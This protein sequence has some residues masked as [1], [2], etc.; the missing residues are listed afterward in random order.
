MSKFM[1]TAL[2]FKISWTFSI[3]DFRRTDKGNIRHGL[4]DIVMLMIFARMSKCMGRAD[5]IEFGRYN[6]GKFQSMGFLR[7]GVPSEPTL[8]RVENGIDELGFAERMA[9]LSKEFH[10]ELV[11][12]SAFLK[13]ICIDGKAMCG[14]IQR[15]GRNPDIVSAYSPPPQA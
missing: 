7:N 8:C 3:P 1:A 9:A 15:N 5:I 4:G 13:I 12:L 11:K 10:N 6:L 2:S 14:T